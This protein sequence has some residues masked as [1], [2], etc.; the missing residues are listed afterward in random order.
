MP[1]QTPPP[2][3]PAAPHGRATNVFLTL[4]LTVAVMPAAAAGE[5]FDVND[6]AV[7]W[8]VP[9]APADVEALVPADVALADAGQL[10]PLT[11]FD[12]ILELADGVKITSSA[13]RVARIGL[14]R[15]FRD[16]TVWKVVAFRVDGSAPGGHA[17]VIGLFGSDPQFRVTLQPVTVS[18]GRVEVHDV[19]AHLVFHFVT[20]EERTGDGPPGPV[21]DRPAFESLLDNL[22]EVRRS[23]ADAGVSTD[24]PLGVHPG[25]GAA[26][27]AGFRDRLTAI[28][29]KH[30]RPDRLR[31]VS[32]M[33]LDPPEPWLFFAA[34][35]PDPDAALA[36]TAVPSL[37]PATAQMLTMRNPAR[38]EMVPLPKNRQFGD[39][40]VSTAPLFAP[41]ARDDLARPALED[42]PPRESP[43]LS[44][45]P[46]IIAN[47][48]LSHFFNTDCVSCHSESSRRQHLGLGGE[49]GSFAFVR[50]PELSA[51]DPDLLPADDWNV[52][53][54]GWF[55]DAKGRFSAAGPGPTVATVTVRTANE[56]AEAV[57]FINREYPSP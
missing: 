49:G 52:R 37:A 23:L 38:T 28:I 36:L 54:F 17:D 2:I 1:T 19:A 18:G 22:R 53:M 48:R 43:T 50:P 57:E 26:E 55:P 32:L 44:D 20:G 11:D 8:P 15:E 29:Q 6:L 30:L 3:S 27:S 9:L 16:R 14:R 4:S 34:A 31:A 33:A 40:G 45:I 41:G 35:R 42:V 47:P 13:G 51:G 7:L 24:V 5:P 10:W 25:F 39:R 21:A 56:A 12:R 46:D